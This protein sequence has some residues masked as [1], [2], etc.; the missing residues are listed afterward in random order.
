MQLTEV[1]ISKAGDYFGE[2]ALIDNKPRAATIKT[3]EE[4]YF[5][6]LEKQY[7]NR[8]LSYKHYI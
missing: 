5:A 1:K 4:S 7:Y 2:L 3:L 8:I 6:V